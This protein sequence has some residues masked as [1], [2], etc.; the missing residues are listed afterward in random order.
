M[1]KGGTKFKLTKRK[2]I[3][4]KSG[5]GANKK[6]QTPPGKVT[7]SG[8]FSQGHKNVLSRKKKGLQPTLEKKK[9]RRMKLQQGACGK[10]SQ[11]KWIDLQN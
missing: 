8:I 4:E 11:K 7:Q 6:P 10:R 2:K 9:K 3:S 1:G 5:R